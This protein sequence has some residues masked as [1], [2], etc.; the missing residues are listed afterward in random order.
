MLVELSDLHTALERDE[1]V[2][3]FQPVV[4]LRTGRLAGFEVLARWQHPQHG[5]VLPENFILLA[6][7]NGLI[8]ALT[9]QVFRKAF[10]AAPLLPEPLVL[11][12]NVSPTQL[13]HLSFCPGEIRDLAEETGFPLKRLTVEITE[14]AVVRTIWSVGANHRQ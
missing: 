7:K 9:R 3:S 11:A 10:S 4:E 5:L 13:H 1:V 12:V 14:S 2:P 6:E 8:G